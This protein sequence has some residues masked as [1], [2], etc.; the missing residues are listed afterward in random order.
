VSI[1]ITNVQISFRRISNRKIAGSGLDE[2][3]SFVS[4]YLIISA[5]LGLGGFTIYKK[6]EYQVQK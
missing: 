4:M 2:V 3:K 1:K 5:A 6:T